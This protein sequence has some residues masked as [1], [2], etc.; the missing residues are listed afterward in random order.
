M[1]GDNLNVR[2]VLRRFKSSGICLNLSRVVNVTYQVYIS[3]KIKDKLPTALYS[4][5]L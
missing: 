5:A 4:C 1:D 2:E 3:E